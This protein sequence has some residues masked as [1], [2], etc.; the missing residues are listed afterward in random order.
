[1]AYQHR[2]GFFHPTP[3]DDFSLDEIDR[4]IDFIE[5]RKE[6]FIS[7]FNDE[8]TS[9]WLWD[10]NKLSKD[11]FQTLYNTFF[12][13]P[14]ILDNFKTAL[15]GDPQS[16]TLCLNNGNRNA[17]FQLLCDNADLTELMAK[18]LNNPAIEKWYQQHYI[19]D[20]D[21]DFSLDEIVRVIDFIEK[22]KEFFISLFSD[23]GT[24]KW[25]WDY[26]KL[27]KGFFQTLYNTFFKNPKIL[28]NF[29]TA[30]IGDSQS[31]TPYLNNV[32]RNAM[33]QLLCDN[34]DLTELMAKNL[35]NPAIKEWCSQ[36]IDKAINCIETRK[37]FFFALF[38]DILNSRKWA[39]E[40]YELSGGFFEALHEK[41]FDAPP[42]RAQ[43]R[44]A[45]IGHPDYQPD[46]P[47]IKN[48]DQNQMR[49]LL[50]ENVSLAVLIAKNLNN[51]A[52]EKWYKQHPTCKPHPI[53]QRPLT[54]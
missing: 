48:G 24:S 18:N 50:R 53:R 12:N 25:I 54:M 7:L 16:N 17:M 27:S 51:H 20:N 49:K 14:K 4:V 37:E 39:K 29:K 41:V 52:I 22:R 38:E 40:N 42:D 3:D 45:L 5:K 11:F 44:I 21:D 30:L 47:C 34:A 31:N 8:S 32:N 35:N 28:N 46:T 15:I 19:V 6:F 33:F 9:L 26:N 23:A 43:F 10:N 1:M 36:V 2:N 13:N